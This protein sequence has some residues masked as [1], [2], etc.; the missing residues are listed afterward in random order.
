VYKE[1]WKMEIT[2]Q[3]LIKSHLVEK[4]DNDMVFYF[5]IL[6]NTELDELLEYMIAI[7]EM[8]FR[9]YNSPAYYF[10]KGVWR[11][12]SAVDIIGKK[13]LKMKPWFAFCKKF[14]GRI[15]R[16][17]NH[18]YFR[19]GNVLT[20]KDLLADAKTYL[21]QSYHDISKDPDTA[22]FSIFDS[23]AD[24]RGLEQCLAN[25]KK[26]K[27]RLKRAFPNKSRWSIVDLSEAKKLKLKHV[28]TIEYK[29]SFQ[30]SLV[31]WNFVKRKLRRIETNVKQF[32]DFKEDWGRR[33]RKQ[34]RKLLKK[35][36]QRR[37]NVKRGVL[38]RF[39]QKCFKTQIMLFHF[40][41]N[42]QNIIKEKDDW[43]IAREVPVMAANDINIT[44]RSDKRSRL[45]VSRDFKQA[46]KGIV[47]KAKKI[48]GCYQG[49]IGLIHPV[50]YTH[51]KVKKPLRRDLKKETCEKCDKMAGA[52]RL[53]MLAIKL[54]GADQLKLREQY[55]KDLRDPN[56]GESDRQNLEAMIGKS[57]KFSNISLD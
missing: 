44:Y 15:V 34:T 13:K 17:I 9:S 40:R 42:K 14:K 1:D 3:K 8:G 16:A 19:G 11:I 54:K 31:D 30:P 7:S 18:Y 22:I 32:V 23:H 38:T 21:A 46:S 45:K 2:M 48:C 52:Y 5:K 27:R 35:N 43:V 12:R 36:F 29:H 57:W 53:T 51:K 28:R 26:G 55:I 56:I 25:L 47:T 41:R 33:W 20:N 24:K 6:N 4:L 37:I 49:G 50:N 39:I 10:Y